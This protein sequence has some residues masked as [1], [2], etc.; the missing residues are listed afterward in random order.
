MQVG[1]LDA[2]GVIQ[3]FETDFKTRGRNGETDDPIPPAV[4]LN[5]AQEA[6]CLTSIA[7]LQRAFRDVDRRHRV[8]VRNCL[9]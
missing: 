9:L 1:G 8:R 7:D 2:D 4:E 5:R 3:A 6:V